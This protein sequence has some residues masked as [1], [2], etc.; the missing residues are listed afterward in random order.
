MDNSV[1]EPFIRIARREDMIWW[2]AWIIRGIALLLSL[3]VCAVVI[4][5]IVKMN[6]INVYQ[7]MFKGAFGRTRRPWITIRDTMMLLCI[8]IGLAPAFKMKFWNIGA[9]G[10]ILVGGVVTAACMIYLTNFPTP[11]LFLAMIATSCIAGAMW[12]F[13]PAI[14]KDELRCDSANLLCGCKVGKSVWFKHRRHYKFFNKNRLD[15]GAFR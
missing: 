7:T 3:V 2:K 10:Q 15:A 4:F 5:A 12:G 14:F 9:E 6:P 8:S 11:L 1:Q 13:L